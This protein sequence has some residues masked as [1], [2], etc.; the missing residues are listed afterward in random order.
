MPR[1]RGIA[2]VRYEFLPKASIE[3]G[4]PAWSFAGAEQGAACRRSL[5]DQDRPIDIRIA[6]V[7]VIVLRLAGF[8]MPRFRSTLM[9]TAWLAL[10]ALAIQ[11]IAAFGHVHPEDFAPSDRQAT[12][13]A[14][15]FET[16]CPPTPVSPGQPAEHDN[17]CAICATLG[18]V[19]SMV[20]PAPPTIAPI[21][22]HSHIWVPPTVATIV[23]ED[24]RA[25]FRARAPPV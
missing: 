12:S 20:L 1:L 23:T 7:N 2:I 25:H 24:L 14:C 15:R 6:G 10:F 22:V 17:F 21:I 9:S 8:L 13:M 19:G 4:R 16:P 11:G 3:Q 5:R 18:L